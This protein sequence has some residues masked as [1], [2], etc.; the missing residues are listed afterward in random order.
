MVKI[1]HLEVREQFQL[2]LVFDDGVEKTI[3][4]TQF[5]TKNT[6]LTT[7]LADPFYFKQVRIYDNGRGLY[8]PNDYDICPDN[9]RYHIHAL[10]TDQTANKAA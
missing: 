2:H 6:Q 3:D 9:L 8:W 10:E 4:G 1:I 7:A 5:I